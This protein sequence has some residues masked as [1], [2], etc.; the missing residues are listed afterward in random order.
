MN[1]RCD[2]YHNRFQFRWHCGDTSGSWPPEGCGQ[3]QSKCPPSSFATIRSKGGLFPVLHPSH[4]YSNCLFVAENSWCYW[5]TQRQNWISS[6]T[7]H[8]GSGFSFRF[9]A[10]L[11]ISF[12]TSFLFTVT[13]QFAIAILLNL[14][15]VNEIYQFLSFIIPFRMNHFRLGYISLPD[16]FKLTF[17]LKRSK[18]LLWLMLLP[19]GCVWRVAHLPPPLRASDTPTTNSAFPQHSVVRSAIIVI[20][21]NRFNFYNNNLTGTNRKFVLF[22]LFVFWRWL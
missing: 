7:S 16:T 15:T 20:I 13:D 2:G 6:W 9:F 21:G 14:W 18:C 12:S 3:I 5:F 1:G 11:N 19:C 8:S 22:V 4:W 17:R 10:P